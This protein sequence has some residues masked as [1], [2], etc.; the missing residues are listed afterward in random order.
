MSDFIA[1]NE[2]RQEVE[3]GGWPS[4]VVFD[5]STHAVSDFTAA[6]TFAGGYAVLTGAGYA[7]QSQ[8]EPAATGLGSK[9]F[10][11]MSFSN[12]SATDWG[13]PKSIVARDSNKLI[14]AW[15][16]IPGGAARSMAQPGT[17][18]KATPVYAPTNPS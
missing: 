4:T 13:S 6:D 18:L 8:A 14:C 9:S 2:G 3:D 5:L 10:A 1:F 17:V 12:G 15:N 11:Q 7:A 16:L